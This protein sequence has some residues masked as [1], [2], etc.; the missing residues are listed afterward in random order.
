MSKTQR[1]APSH[2]QSGR[3]KS[4]NRRKRSRRKVEQIGT[5]DFQQDPRTLSITV[6]VPTNSPNE[7][8]WKH[9]SKYVEI[10]KG[11]LDRIYNAAIQ[12]CGIGKFG[13][14][15]QSASLTIE[16]VGVKQL[17]EDNLKGGV[18]PVIDTLIELGFLEND[19]P[20]VIQVMDVFQTQVRTYAEEQTRITIIDR[21][22]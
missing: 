1:K 2:V 20:D 18:K 14:P 11:W 12:H 3:R 8:V 5:S 13:L 7:W 15:I 10:K 17:D 6:P 19:T 16:R 22:T 9:W 4:G 21:D